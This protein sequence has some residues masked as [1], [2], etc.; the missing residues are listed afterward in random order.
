MMKIQKFAA[1]FAA[2]ALAAA[3]FAGAACAAESGVTVEKVTINNNGVTLAGDLYR[4]ANFDKSK[5]YP[6]ICGDRPIL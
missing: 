3:L 6:A 5:K 1:L 4:P 2:G